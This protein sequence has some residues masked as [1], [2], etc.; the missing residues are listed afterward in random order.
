[1]KPSTWRERDSPLAVRAV[2]RNADVL[3]RLNGAK[4]ESNF[5]CEIL[6]K[7]RPSQ[8]KSL[9]VSLQRRLETFSI[10]FLPAL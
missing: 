2:S 6:T 7:V 1:M 4:F 10:S 9:I 8:F 3:A 5:L